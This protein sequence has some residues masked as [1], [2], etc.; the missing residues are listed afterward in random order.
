MKIMM[1]LQIQMGPWQLPFWV[2][3]IWGGGRGAPLAKASR[4]DS[5]HLPAIDFITYC[6][7]TVAAVPP[8][9]VLDTWDM[10]DHFPVV[11]DLPGLT[12]IPNVGIVPPQPASLYRQIVMEEKELKVTVAS[13]NYWQ[14]LADSLEEDLEEGIECSHSLENP[15]AT[16]R[17]GWMVWPRSLRLV[18]LVFPQSNNSCIDFPNPKCQAPFFYERVGLLEKMRFLLV[19]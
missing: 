16:T 19:K 1:E 17:E 18:Y 14:P 5:E 8:A 6:G 7:N 3:P 9:R 15:P 4:R 2:L 10:S 11:V 13:I 12:R